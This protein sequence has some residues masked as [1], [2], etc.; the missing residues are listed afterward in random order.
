MTDTPTHERI[1]TWLEETVAVQTRMLEAQVPA[2]AR[3]A[4]LLTT[5]LRGGGKVVLFGNGGSAG[6]AQ[7]VA[8][9]LVSR[10]KRERAALPALALTT[11][12]SIL[13]AIANDYAVDQ[14]FAR[15]VRALVRPG[16]LA[17][18]IT[19]SG[20]SPNVLNAIVAARECG[21]RTLG[22]TGQRGGRL[23]DLVDFCFHAPSDDTAHI[24]EAHI[25]VWHAVCLVVEEDVFG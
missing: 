16:D 18:G 20:T 25:A 11:D 17:V 4:E 6:D 3:V 19:T 24:Q 14:I 7:H 10:F 9:E 21:A 12:T 23:R 13:T 5:T 22:L 1:R 15:Q 8:A 2:I